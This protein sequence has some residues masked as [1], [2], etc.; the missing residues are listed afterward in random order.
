MST[1]ML[2]KSKRNLPRDVN[3]VITEY[4]AETGFE[5]AD[6][7]SFDEVNKTPSFLCDSQYTK[8]HLSKEAAKTVDHY[9]VFIDAEDL[10]LQFIL[11]G[12]ADVWMVL[13]A[14]I[15]PGPDKEE[16][17]CQV[18]LIDIAFISS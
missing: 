10:D 18:W 4:I 3:Q 15:P 1:S 9:I 6:M 8:R 2:T 12:F 17:T 11:L 5:T 16:Q 13:Q 14:S 7:Y